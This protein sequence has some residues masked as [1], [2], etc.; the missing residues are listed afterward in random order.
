MRLSKFLGFFPNTFK[1][2]RF[3]TTRFD[4]C[5]TLFF[6]SNYFIG[7]HLIVIEVFQPLS[8]NKVSSPELQEIAMKLVS[9]N[10]IFH[11]NIFCLISIF[12]RFK[13]RQFFEILI[14]I[15]DDLKSIKNEVDYKRFYKFSW[16]AY[17]GVFGLQFLLSLLS[18][19]LS[20]L[21]DIDVFSIDSNKT[22]LFVNF[23]GT[24]SLMLYMNFFI[25]LIYSVKIRFQRINTILKD[26]FIL[27]NDFESQNKRLLINKIGKIHAK[28]IDLTEIINDIFSFPLSTM[29]AN[30]F[31]FSF[32]ASFQ[33]YYA[34]VHDIKFL[35]I[36]FI[37]L[38][39][40][41]YYLLFVLG[42][43]SVSSNLEEMV[44]IFFCLNWER[45]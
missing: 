10:T 7:Y 29:I 40:S 19:I 38:F 2:G 24:C 28:L 32:F 14:S 5:I 17:V 23:M 16:M 4:F 33:V 37:G 22:L 13:M 44:R 6:F 45:P 15:D 42:A 31:L 20:G 11:A 27:N 35:L 8:L 43:F 1:N 39:W 12:K 3:T 9:S 34:F 30:A 41:L 21:S 25:F 36:A 26:Y 18:R